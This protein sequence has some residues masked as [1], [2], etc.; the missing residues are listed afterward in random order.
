MVGH[1]PP[2]INWKI[3]RGIFVLTF[4]P[5]APFCP[6]PCSKVSKAGNK[7]FRVDWKLPLWVSCAP[8]REGGSKLVDFFGDRFFFRSFF[9]GGIYVRNSQKNEDSDISRTTLWRLVEW[10]DNP[11]KEHM[12][13]KY[14]TY[15]GIMGSFYHWRR[16][17]QFVFFRFLVWKSSTIPNDVGTSPPFFW[18]TIFLML[19]L[20]V[21]NSC[22]TW[23]VW[24]PVSWTEICFFPYQLASHGLTVGAL[25]TWSGNQLLTV[26][27]FLAEPPV[28]SEIKYDNP[29]KMC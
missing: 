20:M 19:L 25:K 12:V 3:F 8:L 26:E 4:A 28:N 6:G 18:M 10:N 22:T 2:T 27:M 16:F 7:N 21:Q 24:N 17:L 23:Y 11:P 1:G 9:L 14:W 15:I 5:F 13:G 29:K